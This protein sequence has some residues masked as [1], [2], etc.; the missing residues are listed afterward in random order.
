MSRYKL[1][2]LRFLLNLIRV[3]YKDDRQ[4]FINNNNVKMC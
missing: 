2:L 1:V 3:N 4:I